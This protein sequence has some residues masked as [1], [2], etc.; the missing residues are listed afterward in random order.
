MSLKHFLLFLSDILLLR[1][2]GN[3]YTHCSEKILSLKIF[4]SLLNTL[5]CLQQFEIF[6]C[7]FERSL[8]NKKYIFVWVEY[9]SGEIIYTKNYYI[10]ISNYMCVCMYLHTHTTYN[11]RFAEKVWNLDGRQFPDYLCVPCS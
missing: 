9:Y 5:R 8:G 10:W 4:Y 11:F 6:T 3:Q 2:N 1:C 7:Y